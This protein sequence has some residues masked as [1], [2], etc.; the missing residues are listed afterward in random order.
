MATTL[1]VL[2]TLI[3]CVIELCLALYSKDMISECAREG[4]RYAE[5]RGAT[6]P[7][8]ANPTCEASATQVNSY[9][10][11]LGW[12]NLGAGTMTPATTYPD[13]N[14]NVGSRVQ[15]TVTYVFPIKVPLVPKASLTM[16]STSQAYILQ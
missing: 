12:P 6:C 3:F 11:H 13:G 15:V 14:E 4:T 16:S 9:V 2:L 10:S 7:T 5:Y 8:A 1:T